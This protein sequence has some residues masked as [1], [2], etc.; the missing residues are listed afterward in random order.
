MGQKQITNNITITVTQT[1]NI[2]NT[3][4]KSDE[5]LAKNNDKFFKINQNLKQHHHKKGNNAL[6]IK[7]KFLKKITPFLSD[8]QLKN[9]SKKNKN[10]LQKPPKSIT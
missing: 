1:K 9:T 8:N 4:S 10:L 6:P 2:W 7:E 5:N 3:K